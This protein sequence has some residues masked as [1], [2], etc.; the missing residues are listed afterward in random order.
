MER[1]CRFERGKSFVECWAVE[2]EEFSHL[3]WK[4]RRS[5]LALG[6]ASIDFKRW[7]VTGT[8]SVSALRA[9]SRWGRFNS[10]FYY[11]QLLEPSSSGF[12]VRITLSSECMRD[13]LN[14]MIKDWHLRTRIPESM[15]FSLVPP[16]VLLQ[17][18]NRNS[19]ARLTIVS[20]KRSL[21]EGYAALYS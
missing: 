6:P 9:L 3:E 1:I 21:R 12:R 14:S 13:I 20:L 18:R 2:R 15:A 11:Q 17:R 10:S 7:S 8:A 4:T 16:L 5:K 19:D